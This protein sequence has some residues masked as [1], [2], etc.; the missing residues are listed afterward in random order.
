MVASLGGCRGVAGDASPVLLTAGL[1]SELVTRVVVL[2]DDVVVAICVMIDVG[3]GVTM[4]TV[5]LLEVL[6][7]IG[8]V[9]NAN[10][11]RST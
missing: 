5:T 3:V 6:L 1:E 7:L 4:D 2:G 9:L 10:N 11:S 8:D